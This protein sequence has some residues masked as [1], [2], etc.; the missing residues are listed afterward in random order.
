VIE[1]FRGDERGIVFGVLSTSQ[2][3]SLLIVP[4]SLVMLVWLARQP[5]TSPGTARKSLRRAS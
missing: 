2:F 5:Q 1:F 4:V 3:I